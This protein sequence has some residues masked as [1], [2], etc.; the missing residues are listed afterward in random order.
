MN[1]TQ[2]LMNKSPLPIKI[3]NMTATCYWNLAINSNICQLC[4]KHL[5]NATQDEIDHKHVKNELEI[6]KCGCGFHSDCFSA[7]VKAGNTMCPVDN[8]TWATETTTTN[9]VI[10]NTLT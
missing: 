7:W 2:P 3:K 4:H 5:M 8:S 10:W 1:N 6:G 9:G